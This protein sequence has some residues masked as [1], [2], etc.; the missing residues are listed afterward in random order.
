MEYRLAYRALLSV[1]C[2]LML[3]SGYQSVTEA[4]SMTKAGLGPW[5]GLHA[6]AAP[7]PG[8]MDAYHA[9]LR[10]GKE[11][12]IRRTTLDLLGIEGYDRSRGVRELDFNEGAT[13]NVMLVGQL[14]EQGAPLI[15]FGTRRGDES[16]MLRVDQDG[17]VLSAARSGKTTVE[18]ISAESTV[19][20]AGLQTC[21][22]FWLKKARL[23]QLASI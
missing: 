23:G 2:T 12:T 14:D 13:Q 17:R 6:A 11:K 5:A 20:R 10:N 9:V 16:L 21:R 15:I 18:K 8:L 19:V 1:L 4:L 7:A 3:Q 22:E